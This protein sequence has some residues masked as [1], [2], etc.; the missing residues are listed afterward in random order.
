MREKSSRLLLTKLP[1]G[2]AE[3]AR[4]AEAL[5]CARTGRWRCR[6]GRSLGDGA[7]H[8]CEWR[9]ELVTDV[10]EESRLGA[11][12]RRQCLGP[13]PLGLVGLR[14]GNRCGKLP[15]H[16]IEK[17]PIGII[18]RPAR[19]YTG[20]ENG[21]R[22]GRALS[23]NGQDRRLGNELFRPQRRSNTLA[24]CHDM[25]VVALYRTPQPPRVEAFP[26]VTVAGRSRLGNVPVTA[27]KPSFRCGL[28]DHVEGNGMDPSPL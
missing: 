27:G 3:V 16:Q 8:E 1:A 22:L 4:W 23:L 5:S 20:Y 10:G 28:V 6:M 18:E 13:L 9:A 12:D 21:A 17:S 24:E 2:A 25:R 19:G 14:I 15:R 11:I 26:S 7:E